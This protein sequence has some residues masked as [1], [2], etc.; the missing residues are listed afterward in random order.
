MVVV[1]T[2]PTRR[3]EGHSSRTGVRYKLRVTKFM[4]EQFGTSWII[5]RLVIHCNAPPELGNTLKANKA[6]C[7]RLL[8][9]RYDA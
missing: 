6:S 4:N 3:D 7:W 5:D 1:K 8:A 2:R 9:M